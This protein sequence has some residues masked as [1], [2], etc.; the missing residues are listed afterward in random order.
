MQ[1][2]WIEL[3][4]AVPYGGIAI[5]FAV[6]VVILN[7]RQDRKDKEREARDDARE[8][9]RIAQRKM[10]QERQ[11]RKDYERDERFIK[12][13]ADLAHDW[14]QALATYAVRSAESIATVARQLD[15]IA[16]MAMQIT[17]MLEKHDTWERAIWEARRRGD[18]GPL[19]EKK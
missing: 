8:T 12:A 19:S 1:I 15:H 11:D 2:D 14:Q 17:T 13:F 5:I 6:F 4:R 7:E 10:D 9:V 16:D 18:T 3:S